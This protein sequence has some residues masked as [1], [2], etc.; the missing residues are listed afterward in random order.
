[1]STSNI[2]TKTLSKYVDIYPDTC[3]FGVNSACPVL[4]TNATVVTDINDE[5][6]LLNCKDVSNCDADTS[7]SE[8]TCTAN[9][10]AV[11]GYKKIQDAVV[12]TNKACNN[13]MY[14]AG[15]KVYSAVTVTVFAWLETG[16][17]SCSGLCNSIPMK[18]WSDTNV[19]VDPPCKEVV[20]SVILRNYKIVWPVALV[21]MLFCLL[22]V[23]ASF[24]ICCHPLN[25]VNSVRKEE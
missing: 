1:M 6:A 24:C 17:Y 19:Q 14:E 3:T 20:K 9:I 18:Y 5:V 23:L 22:S 25:K 16:S 11:S 10:N 21:I 8:P 4:V 2:I 15:V 12:D 13:L 7:T